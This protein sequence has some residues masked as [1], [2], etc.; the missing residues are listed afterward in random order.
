MFSSLRY[1]IRLLW[2]SPGFTL[3]AVP[4]TS[5][6]DRRKHCDVCYRRLSLDASAA[7]PGSGPSGEDRYDHG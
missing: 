3:V 5:S 4:D 6:W 2:K 1:A 7:I